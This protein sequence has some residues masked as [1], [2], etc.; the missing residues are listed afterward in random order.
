MPDTV[1][2]PAVRKPRAAAVKAQTAEPAPKAVPA[3]KKAAT[4]TNGKVTQMISREEIAML[5][6]RFWLER[7]GQHGHHE[8]DWL[9]AEQTL[10]GKAS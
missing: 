6:H 7:G 3:K 9:R 4:K 10:L 8:E 5:A 1:K 2:K